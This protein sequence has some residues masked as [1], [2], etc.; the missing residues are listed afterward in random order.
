VATRRAQVLAALSEG[1]LG[2]SSHSLGTLTGGIYSKLQ[3]NKPGRKKSPALSL[4]TRHCHHDRELQK[5][6]AYPGLPSPTTGGMC[7]CLRALTAGISGM[8]S[9]S[10]QGG[11]ILF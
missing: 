8:S 5:R 10:C 4:R 9:G 1:E 2:F 11:I 7:H 6:N 3:T